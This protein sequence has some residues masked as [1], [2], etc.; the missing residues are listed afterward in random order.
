MTSVASE[1]PPPR[2][3]QRGSS[4]SPPTAHVRSRLRL[5]VDRRRPGESN[6]NDDDD[7]DDDDDDAAQS[8]TATAS[9]PGHKLPPLVPGWLPAALEPRP[10]PLD[11]PD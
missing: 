4:A 1:R 9:R 6:L 8:T 7:D 5:R 2:E 10:T 3:T 11:P